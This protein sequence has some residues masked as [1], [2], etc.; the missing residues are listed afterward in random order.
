[1]PVD[2]GG[3]VRFSLALHV[4]DV[5]MPFALFNVLCVIFLHPA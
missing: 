3:I 2:P 1:M 4:V 5:G